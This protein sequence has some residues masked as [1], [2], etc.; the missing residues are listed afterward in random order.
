MKVDDEPRRGYGT[1]SKQ[2]GRKQTKKYLV[3][4]LDVIIVENR[5]IITAGRPSSSFRFTIPG[6]PSSTSTLVPSRNDGS[7]GHQP[8]LPILLI[9]SHLFSFCLVPSCPVLSRTRQGNRETIPSRPRPSPLLRWQSIKS[10]SQLKA[11]QTTSTTATTIPL[12]LLLLLSFSLTYF[13]MGR[14]RTRTSICA[15]L[16]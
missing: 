11:L 5:S 14:K 9:S 4:G 2:E 13:Y 12:L 7:S 15:C 6:R 10:L 3:S 16:C 8:I 1:V